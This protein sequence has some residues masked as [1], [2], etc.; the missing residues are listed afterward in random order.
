MDLKW[1]RTEREMK[2][3]ESVFTESLSVHDLKLLWM[4]R[5]GGVKIQKS[6]VFIFMHKL[7]AS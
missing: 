2:A 5:Q 1:E 4:L 7:G 6:D 3:P